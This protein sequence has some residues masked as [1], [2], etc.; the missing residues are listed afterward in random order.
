MYSYWENKLS[1]HI[2]SCSFSETTYIGVTMSLVVKSA[3]LDSLKALPNFGAFADIMPGLVA[4]LL[5]PRRILATKKNRIRLNE[6]NRGK[7][8]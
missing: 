6:K 8:E 7:P 5:I 1:Y 4:G 3:I 2:I